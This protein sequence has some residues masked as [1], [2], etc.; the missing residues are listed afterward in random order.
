MEYDVII[1]GAG[2]AGLT[3][4]WKLA[5]KGNKVLVIDKKASASEVQY[6]TAGSFIDVEK[7]KI[8]KSVMQPI[9]SIYL[10]SKNVVIKRK[11]SANVINRKFLLNWLGKKCE[12][13]KV[14]FKFKSIVSDVIFEKDGIKKIKIGSEDFMAKIFV[15]CSGMGCV[16]AKKMD[17][18]PKKYLLAAGAEYLVPLKSE[19]GTVDLFIGSE[20][21]GGYGWIFPINDNE[22]IIGYGTF[23]AENKKKIRKRLDDMWNIER[24]RERCEF[25]PKE[26]NAAVFRTGKPLKSFV[27]GNLVLIGDVA[28][29]GNPLVGEGIRFV[30]DSAEMAAEAIDAALK[31]NKLGE[32][33]S[34]NKRWN[35]KYRTA[36]KIAFWL[37][38]KIDKISGDDAA[39][40]NKMRKLSKASDATLVKILKADFGYAYFV[41]KFFHYLRKSL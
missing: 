35:K 21:K 8:P 6:Y 30:M 23:D 1:V 19:P 26:Y 9:N 38:R 33:K 15:D 11:G 34:Y 7:W 28:L 32:L 2:P 16:L 39:L 25:R 29:Q 18:T 36:F 4:A 17:F 10:A 20:F 37:Q 5:E 24:V 27:K 31:K 12:D 22:A 41:Q 13:S 3:C 40:D 14:D